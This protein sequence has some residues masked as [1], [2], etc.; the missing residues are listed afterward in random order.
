MYVRYHTHKFPLP[1]PLC[2][3]GNSLPRRLPDLVRP[4][5]VTLDEFDHLPRQEFHGGVNNVIRKVLVALARGAVPFGEGLELE[6]TAWEVPRALGRVPSDRHNVNP[7]LKGV[8]FL[9]LV[10][11]FG[12]WGPKVL[13]LLCNPKPPNLLVGVGDSSQPVR[14][15]SLNGDAAGHQGRAAGDR[16][17]GKGK[18]AGDGK[19]DEHPLGQRG[20]PVAPPSRIAGF[21]VGLAAPGVGER[22]HGD[23]EQQSRQAGR[24]AEYPR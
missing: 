19:E 18:T 3:S 1:P 11:L 8:A 23:E 20:L 5:S 4:I 10:T 14:G 12:N 9:C 21:G 7:N 24:Q 15:G 22:L 13:G 17:G 2:A 6:R 16:F